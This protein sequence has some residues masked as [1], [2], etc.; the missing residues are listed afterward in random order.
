MKFK[1]GDIIT[2]HEYPDGIRVIVEEVNDN[3]WFWSKDLTVPYQRCGEK[4]FHNPKFWELSKEHL[5][6]S[7][8]EEILR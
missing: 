5:R 1:I 6:N 8:I 2:Y 3:G 7:K 4:N